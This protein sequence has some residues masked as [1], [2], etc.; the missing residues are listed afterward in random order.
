[1]LLAEIDQIPDGM[2]VDEDDLDRLIVATS[3]VKL[4][5]ETRSN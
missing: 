2:Q 4:A 1:M 3:R 5:I